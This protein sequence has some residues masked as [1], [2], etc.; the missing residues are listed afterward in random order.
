MRSNGRYAAEPP[1]FRTARTAS[2]EDILAAD[3]ILCFTN[4]TKDAAN[5]E[6]RK[7]RGFWQPFP[8]AGEPVMCLRNVPDLGLFNG[9]V[10]ELGAPFLQG[11]RDIS[12]NVDGEPITVRD[13]TFKGIASP[14]PDDVE[15]TT[16]FDFGYAMTVH[17][18]QGSEWARV[19][20]LDEYN[21]ADN[22]RE[23]L[24][25]GITRAAESIL[26]LTAQ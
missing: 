14:L 5:A 20:L 19:I 25:T 3:A 13:V 4:R 24:Y 22:R 21:R 1:D 6:A 11:D 10:Y 17:K 23:W 18:A 16:S 15:P 12:L 8:Q 7:V 2:N 26:M 9:A